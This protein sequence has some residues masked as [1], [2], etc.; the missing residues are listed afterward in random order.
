MSSDAVKTLVQAFISCR[1]D[2]CNSI[3]TASPTVWWAGCSRVWCRALDAMSRLYVVIGYDN[4][5]KAGKAGAAGAAH[6]LPVRRRVY[7]RLNGSSSPVLTATSL[8]YLCKKNCSVYIQCKGDIVVVDIKHHKSQFK[9]FKLYHY[10]VSKV[11]LTLCNG[12][13]CQCDAGNIT[14]CNFCCFQCASP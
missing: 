9:K 11:L 14:F 10:T 2:Y 6:W 4:N 5:H 13:V 1:L 12:D 7:H 8:S 3:S